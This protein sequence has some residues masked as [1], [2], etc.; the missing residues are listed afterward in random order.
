MIKFNWI[1]EY[2]GYKNMEKT[3]YIKKISEYDAENAKKI[4]ESLK[5][6]LRANKE[7]LESANRIDVQVSKKKIKLETLIEIVDNYKEAYFK[8]LDKVFIVYYKGDPYLTINLFIQA[9]M[10]RSK[11][12][13]A[14]DEFMLSTNEILFTIFSKILKEYKIDNLINKCQYSKEK[15]F[16]IKDL[17]DAEIIGI[18]DTTMYQVL[19]EEGKFYSYYNIMLYCDNEMLVPIK[20]A[21]YVY[22]NENNYELEIVY[23]DNIEDAIN[24]MN[25]VETT[26]IVV[27]LSNNKNTIKKFKEKI[28][29]KL[30][31]N[32][33]PF[34]KSYGK[35]YDYLK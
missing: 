34:I 14:Y 4:L 13:F 1:I 24:Y 19:N 6:N 17:L 29:K 12:I 11:I 10:S 35:I 26:N 20:D 21:I 15:I 7:I 30:F 9:L 3:E 16:E 18:G 2:K 8:N 27:L 5:N 25:I 22:S 33:N 28:N 31:I 32:E 23:E